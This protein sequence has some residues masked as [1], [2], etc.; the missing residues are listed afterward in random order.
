MQGYISFLNLK[1]E[2][3]QAALDQMTLIKKKC[4]LFT[5]VCA[6]AVPVPSP[7]EASDAMFGDMFRM[8]LVM[9]NAM[10]DAML[11]NNAGWGGGD[12]F[13]LGMTAWPAMSGMSGMSPWSG[14]T[15]V[16]GVNPVTGFGGVPGMSPW[17][18]VPGMNTWSA[19]MNN[20]PWANHLTNAYPS[21]ASNPYTNPA[22]AGYQ[23]PQVSFLDGR[24]YGDSGELLEIRGNRFRLQDEQSGINGAIRIENNLASLYSPQT[25]TVSQYTFIRNQSELLLQDATG[26]VLSFSL[27]PLGGITHTF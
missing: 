21:N 11:D 22:Y 5:L 15:G 20:N 18:G 25:G 2:S 3:T 26:Q 1:T 27:Q 6:L 19:P 7:A 9:M 8:M 23:P 14:M 4:A 17:S 16:P 10:S 24:W 12:S 13:G